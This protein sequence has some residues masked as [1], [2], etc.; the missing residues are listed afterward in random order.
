MSNGD[1]LR[2]RLRDASRRVADET[3]RELDEKLTKLRKATESDLE[4]LKP[5]ITDAAEYEKLIAVVKEANERNESL[6][7]LK[8][9]LKQFGSGMQAVLKQAV[10]LL[11]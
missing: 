2:E 3:D 4:A 7:Q 10:D 8:D 9:R 5:Q 6:A 1:D 11:K